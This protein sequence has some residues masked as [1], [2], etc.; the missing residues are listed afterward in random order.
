MSNNELT[1]YGILGMK[2]GVRRSPE[3]LGRVKQGVVEGAYALGAKANPREHIYSVKRLVNKPNTTQK[4]LAS[5]EIDKSK[6]TGLLTTNE[7]ALKAI[8][9]IGIEKH[10]SVIYNNL[11]DEDIKRFK[12]YTDAAIY[13]RAVNGYLATG[14]PKEFAEK[15]NEL[16]KSLRKNK[17]DNQTVYRSCNLKFSTPGVS[18]KL[19]TYTEAEL[20]KL[21]DSMSSNFKNKTITEN[22]IYSTSTSPLFAIDTWRT[23][24]PTAAKTYNSY[25]IIDC[26][27][28]PGVYAD[29]RTKSGGKLVNTRSNQECILAPNEIVYKKLTYDKERQMFAIHMEAR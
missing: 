29:A 25:L 17:I 28:T 27:N 9:K 26:K 11:N 6:M 19:D 1:H 23:V 16:K 24:N 21:F 3:Q 18:K 13:S 5:L 8:E 12:K 10:K 4:Q 7:E 2:W 22:R 20:S 14:T 15:A